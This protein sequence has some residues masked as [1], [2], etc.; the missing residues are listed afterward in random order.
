MKS[1]MTGRSAGNTLGE[2]H[3]LL[4]QLTAGV[5]TDGGGK[6]DRSS[7]IREYNK[8]F[9]NSIKKIED[10]REW[11]LYYIYLSALKDKKSIDLRASFFALKYWLI[12]FY[13]HG[14]HVHGRYSFRV[15]NECLMMTIRVA[16]LSAQGKDPLSYL[17]F[18]F[19]FIVMLDESWIIHTP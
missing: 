17:T 7:S 19:W 13:C 16:I 9:E 15:E 11:R 12:R 18:L 10:G 6:R 14:N 4:C 3:I 2:R 1:N 5:K 8:W